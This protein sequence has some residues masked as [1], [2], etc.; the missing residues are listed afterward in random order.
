MAS[1]TTPGDLDRIRA[2]QGFDAYVK[3]VARHHGEAAARTAM[4]H[5]TPA[6]QDATITQHH[7]H[8]EQWRSTPEGEANYQQTCQQILATIE[9]LDADDPARAAG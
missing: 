6:E 1:D 4:A 3:A 5:R 8:L 7:R 9:D 2:E